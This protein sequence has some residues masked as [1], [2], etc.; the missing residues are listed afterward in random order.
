VQVDA[1]CQILLEK[2]VFT[3]EEFFGKLKQVQREYEV[4]KALAI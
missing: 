4:K 1:L 2:G 3:Q